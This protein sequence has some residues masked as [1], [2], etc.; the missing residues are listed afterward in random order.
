[1][2]R[3][4]KGS[5]KDKNRVCVSYNKT[6]KLNK[7]P[8]E[9]KMIVPEE[10]QYTNSY[11]QNKYFR[12]TFKIK[13][14]AGAVATQV[15]IRDIHIDLHKNVKDVLIKLAVKCDISNPKSM[16]KIDLVNKLNQCIVFE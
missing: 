10:D 15:I 3:C 6:L 7:T 1:M 13:P 9:K 5:R 12:T 14:R 8:S 2:P 11:N 4:P 16:K